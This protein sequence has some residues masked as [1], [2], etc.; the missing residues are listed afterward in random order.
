M[1]PAATAIQD[2]T[3]DARSRIE[4]A[5]LRTIVRVSR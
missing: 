1:R 2:V 3:V 4:R 5:W